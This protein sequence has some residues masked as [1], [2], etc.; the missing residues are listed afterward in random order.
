MDIVQELQLFYNKQASRF[1]ETR[2]RTWPEFKILLKEIE[3]FPEE[4]KT[5][6]VLEVGCGSWRFYKFLKENSSK[7]ID[8]S[9]V[10]ISKNLIEIAKMENTD[11]HFSVAH[12]KD[13]LEKQKQE[14][15]DVIVWIASFHHLENKTERLFTLELMYR[16][17]KYDGKLL[18]LN[19]AYSERF[20]KKYWKA[21]LSAIWKMFSTLGFW[22][23]NDVLVPRVEKNETY[24]RFYHIFTLRE[25]AI[26]VK[27]SGFSLKL[28]S[29]I[30]RFGHL[31]DKRRF[32]KNSLIV[33]EKKVIFDD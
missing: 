21:Q 17:L 10:D 5:I 22:K 31:V 33:A 4:K 25:I 13:F 24:H 18:L 2:K 16:A 7:I 15:Y 26:L 9:G 23:W 19:W 27:R 12:M 1:H 11:G 29:F 6:K 8:Y 28:L 30:D 32:A 20:L 3:G 14:Q